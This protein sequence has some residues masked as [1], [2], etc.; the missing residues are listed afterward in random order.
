[1]VFLIFIDDVKLKESK[2]DVLPSTSMAAHVVDE[3]VEIELDDNIEK[4]ET[5][6][7]EN[8]NKVALKVND[9]P[10][11]LP[12][13]LM[14]SSKNYSQ[15]SSFSTALSPVTKSMFF[16]FSNTSLSYLWFQLFGKIYKYS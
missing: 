6:H 2:V 8:E 10:L 3:E 7:A 11:L 12:P 9:L 1:M 5:I 4:M 15:V 16:H 13:A 14:S